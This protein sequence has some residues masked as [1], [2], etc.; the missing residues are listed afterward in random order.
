M[1]LTIDKLH[2]H[3]KGREMQSDKSSCQ[4]PTVFV[5][6]AMNVPYPFNP[7]YTYTTDPYCVWVNEVDEYM[8]PEEFIRWPHPFMPTHF[9]LLPEE[10][11]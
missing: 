11:E 9:C 2:E 7:N 3:V 6:I 5:V 1:W 4:S 8:R 10:R